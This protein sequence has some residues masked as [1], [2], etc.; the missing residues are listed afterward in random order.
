MALPT[1]HG[2]IPP[3]ISP[4]TAQLS[5]DAYALERIIEHVIAG[6]VSG[7]FLLG[8]TGE[9]P[10]MSVET[11]KDLIRESVKI[12]SGRI[13]VIVNISSTSYLESR[14]MAEFAATEG[15]SYTVLSPSFYFKMNKSELLNYY[16][17]LAD[18]SPLPLLIYNAPEYTRGFIDAELFKELSS[19]QNIKG[20]KDSS[21]NMAY[22]HE[23]VN[24]RPDESFPILIGPEILLGESLLL[25]CNGG[26][27]GGANLYPELYV[28]LYRAAVEKNMEEMAR[29]QKVIQE[30]HTRLYTVASS[31]MGIVIGLKYLMWKRGLCSARM[32]MP[33][34]ETLSAEKKTILETLHKEILQL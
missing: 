5:L 30:I 13:P 26:V 12:S 18:H 21:G 4:L 28:K 32:A 9:G 3:L 25:G 17:S 33:V 14:Q 27:C 22:I 2:I 10:S 16:W 31:P 6:G 24:V 19:H 1:L 15:S 29:I 23:L 8:S 20:I 34:Y 11:K 7:I